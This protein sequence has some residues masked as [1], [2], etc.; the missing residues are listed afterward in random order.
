MPFL[1]SN[2][3]W[4]GATTQGSDADAREDAESDAD[5]ETDPETGRRRKPNPERRILQTSSITRLDDNNRDITNNTTTTTTTRRLGK[6]MPS[7]NLNEERF[8]PEFPAIS[9]CSQQHR[10]HRQTRGTRYRRTSVCHTQYNSRDTSSKPSVRLSLRMKRVCARACASVCASICLCIGGR[11]IGLARC[12]RRASG[13]RVHL[14]RDAGAS[15]TTEQP[16]GL[17]DH[18]VPC[19]PVSHRRCGSASVCT[20]VCCSVSASE[21]AIGMATTTNDVSVERVSVAGYLRLTGI[22]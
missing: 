17:G 19:Q 20:G 10:R 2:G 7:T 12:M 6:F 4:R 11:E 13:C 22:C 3:K 16:V 1:I 15:S 5:A 18:S 9:Y 14:A 21:H 8:L